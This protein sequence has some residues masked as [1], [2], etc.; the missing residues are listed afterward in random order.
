MS[1][2]TAK[3]VACLVG[4]SSLFNVVGFQAHPKH[5]GSNGGVVAEE[6]FAG[7]PTLELLDVETANAGRLTL[8]VV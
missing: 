6:E 3:R 8:R 5:R 2:R 7:F 4:L 1:T